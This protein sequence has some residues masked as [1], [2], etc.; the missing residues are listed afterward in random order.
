MPRV[1]FNQRDNQP[2]AQMPTPD[3]EKEAGEDTETTSGKGEA[4][5]NTKGDPHSIRPNTHNIHH[6]CHGIHQQYLERMD[7]CFA[8]LTTPHM[9]YEQVTA[10]GLDGV[11]SGRLEDA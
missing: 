4:T 11:L 3:H 10:H 9:R 5:K 8:Q 1:R 7:E 6:W 2:Y